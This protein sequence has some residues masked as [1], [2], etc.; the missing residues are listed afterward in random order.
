M[1]SRAV[2]NGTTNTWT[3]KRR[4][5]KVKK[6]HIHER[7]RLSTGADLYT[8]TIIAP[9][10]GYKLP[11]VSGVGTQNDPSSW[12]AIA[13]AASLPSGPIWMWDGDRR[14]TADMC[15]PVRRSMLI[16]PKSKRRSL[17]SRLSYATCTSSRLWPL[18]CRNITPTFNPPNSGLSTMRDRVSY[19]D[20]S[21]VWLITKGWTSMCNTLALRWPPPPGICL[22]L[23]VVI[24][25]VDHAISWILC[26]LHSI[27]IHLSAGDG[28]MFG[29]PSAVLIT[30]FSA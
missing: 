13:C 17:F 3:K 19:P 11:Y 12:R 27:T 5:L 28:T 29:S 1:C 18:M 10:R 26:R 30:Q 9:P 23:H 16:G 25:G 15:K 20:L 6:G 7:R 21:R 4:N 8:S 2:Y 14:W 22:L 24:M